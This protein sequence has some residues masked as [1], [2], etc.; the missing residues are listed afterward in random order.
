M[1]NG[2]DAAGV[3][4]V[5]KRRLRV[6]HWSSARGTNL[7]LCYLGPLADRAGLDR[8]TVRARPGTQVSRR[9]PDP[10]VELCTVTRTFTSP[11]ATKRG[12]GG[13]LTPANRKCQSTSTAATRAITKLK[14]RRPLPRPRSSAGGAIYRF[15]R[16]ASCH[17]AALARATRFSDD[18]TYDLDD[19]RRLDNGYPRHYRDG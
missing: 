12:G 19:D 7:Y 17:P 18:L 8:L 1:H 6:D 10:A 13:R 15:A 2:R 9:T 11:R 14:W 5:D 4:L 16:S 3:S